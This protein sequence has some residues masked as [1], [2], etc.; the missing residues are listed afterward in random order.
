MLRLV[1][2]SVGEFPVLSGG[3]PVSL[4]DMHV[5]VSLKVVARVFGCEV[6]C[7]GRCVM[8]V[9]RS[10][11]LFS[12]GQFGCGLETRTYA[13]TRRVEVTGNHSASALGRLFLDP[14]ITGE[15]RRGQTA[16]V[17]PT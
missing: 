8:S 6:E 3:G 10:L 17:V 12:G 16:L 13:A 5:R 4:G 7:A 9:G 1:A 11:E 2:V 14:P 15:V